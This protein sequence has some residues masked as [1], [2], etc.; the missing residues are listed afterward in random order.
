MSKFY[1]TTPIY[2]VNAE[3]HIGHAYTTVGIVPEGEGSWC[4]PLDQ[5][6]IL[7]DQTPVEAGAAQLREVPLRGG[8]SS[9][10]DGRQRVCL[11]SLPQGDARSSL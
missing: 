7:P 8:L 2:Y 10:R 9:T 5:R 4:L 3:P 6:R 11:C 1:I